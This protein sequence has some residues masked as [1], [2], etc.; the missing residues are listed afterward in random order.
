MKIAS[1]CFAQTYNG[2]KGTFTAEAAIVQSNVSQL[3]ADI[4]RL[5]AAWTELQQQHERHAILWQKVSGEGDGGGGQQAL[6]D[7][8]ARQLHEQEQQAEQLNKVRPSSG[9]P[10]D[11]IADL[12]SQALQHSRSEKGSAQQQLTM[13]ADL[14][15]LLDVKLQCMRD[16][17]NAGAGGTLMVQQGG[18]EMFT[19]DAGSSTNNMV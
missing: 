10:Y 4:G 17:R 8:F 2:L 12:V 3:T 14:H 7:T 6:R 1:F 9:D 19:L 18:A 11:I 16:A 13:W 15:A 5:E